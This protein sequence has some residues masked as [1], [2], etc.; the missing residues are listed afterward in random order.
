MR[1]SQFCIE[2]AILSYCMLLLYKAKKKK[3]NCNTLKAL[4]EKS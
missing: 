1:I 4:C 2:S 3:K